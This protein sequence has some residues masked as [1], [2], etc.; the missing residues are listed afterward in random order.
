MPLDA[1]GHH[2][3]LLDG[4]D[5]DALLGAGVVGVWHLSTSATNAKRY[6]RAY[7]ANPVGRAVTVA[8]VLLGAG[9][10]ECVRYLDGNPLNVRRANLRLVR[11]GVGVHHDR[12][13]VLARMLSRG[14]SF[15]NGT[16]NGR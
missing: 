2:H 9:D 3:A 13:L 8:R 5:Y 4:S 10:G 16:A 1:R 7:L 6:V 12:I 14:S 11:H 15:G